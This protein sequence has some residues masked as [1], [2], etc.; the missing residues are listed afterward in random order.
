MHGVPHGQHGV[1]VGD[2]DLGTEGRDTVLFGEFGSQLLRAGT[3]QV[4]ADDGPAV[5]SEAVSGGAADTALGPDSGND[6]GALRLL[7]MVFSCGV[8]RGC[9]QS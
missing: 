2:V 6:D 3:V 7:V 8:G 5:A 4:Q 9:G 1:L